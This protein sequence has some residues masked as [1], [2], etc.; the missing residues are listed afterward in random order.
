MPEQPSYYAIIP[1]VVRYCRDLE[2]NAKLLYGEITALCSQEGYCWATNRYFAELYDVEIRTIQY[3]LESLVKNNFILVD[4]SRDNFKTER[5][6]SLNHSFQINVTACKKS[7]EGGVKKVSG[8]RE[9]KTT[10]SITS[11]NT[12]K[13]QQQEPVGS[14]AAFY[15]CIQE[16]GLSAKEKKSLMKY[17]EE[18]VKKAVLYATNP[19]TRIKTNLI[20]TLIWAILEDPDVEEPEDVEK[21]KQY[22]ENAEECLESNQWKLEALHSKVV[23]HSKSPTHTKVYEMP[24]TEIDFKNKLIQ[25]LKELKFTTRIE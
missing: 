13:K 2:P 22:A 24:Y 16:I 3:W 19:K 14:V 6:I 11:S 7:R 17:P 10:Q 21:N 9:R 15:E 25:L 5:K 8:E 23:I 1:A 4:V 20:R 12:S 18:R